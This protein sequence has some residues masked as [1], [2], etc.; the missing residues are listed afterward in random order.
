M[1]PCGGS[2]GKLP[3]GARAHWMRSLLLPRRAQVARFGQG[4]TAPFRIGMGEERVGGRDNSRGD[5]TA[6]GC[7]RCFQ[8]WPEVDELKAPRTRKGWGLGRGMEDRG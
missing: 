5:V 3:A 7:R 2:T 8:I 1:D 4:E 6:A